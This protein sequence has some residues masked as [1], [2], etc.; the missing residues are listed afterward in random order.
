MNS[1]VLKYLLLCSLSIILNHFFKE[2]VDLDKLL[3]NSLSEQFTS[4]QIDK[5]FKF[6]KKWEWIGY[7]FIPILLLI[8]T[9]IIASILYIGLFF[10]NRDLKFSIILNFVLKAEFIFLL[11][12]ISKLIWFYFF[13]TNFIL[14]DIQNF[15]PLSALNIVRYKELEIWFIYPFQV[16]NLFEFFYIIYLGYEIGKH[17]QTNTDYGLKVV[18]LSYVPSLFL[19]VATIMF[20]TLNYN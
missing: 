13:E 8:K 1:A 5:F 7:I 4:N 20:F 18:G 12:P 14:E 19:W 11:V 10:S 16:L 17:T 3:Y 9:S 2:I 6:Q 15:Y